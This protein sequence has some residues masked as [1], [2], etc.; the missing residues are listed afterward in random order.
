MKRMMLVLITLLAFAPIVARA[1]A[2]LEHAEPRV[3]STVS[4]PVQQV[5]L[6][7]SMQV[8]PAKSTMSVLAPDG[9]DMAAGKAF[10]S[11]PSDNATLAIRVRDLLPGK[12]K[13]R[14]NVLAACGSKE[15]GDYKFT[16]Q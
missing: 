8:F 1:C 15:P 6:H 14:W 16:V 12:Y 11:N 7:F 3:G 2:V 9:T 5:T 4:A 10:A 13:V